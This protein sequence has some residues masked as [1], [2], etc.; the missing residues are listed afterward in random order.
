MIGVK[1]AVRAAIGYT[2][3]FADVM[4]TYDL[5]LEETVFDS[6]MGQWKVVLSFSESPVI[7]T[8][9]YKTFIIDG[10]NSEVLSMQTYSS[11]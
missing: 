3:D 11:L 10:D 1:Q 5:R 8:R 7:S 6:D 9:S 4:P 2:R